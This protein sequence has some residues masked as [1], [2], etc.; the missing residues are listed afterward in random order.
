MFNYPKF[1]EVKGEKYKINT[2][3]KIALKCNE[4]AESDN[5]SKEE[6]S[7]A[8]IYLLFGNEG[9]EASE[10]WKELLKIAIKYLKCG[11]D[12]K[13]DNK[14]ADVSYIQDIRYIETS[15]YYD[16]QID[17]KSTQMHWWEFYE[18]LCGLSEKCILNRIRYIRN[19]D[20]SQIKD[21]KEKQK[22]IEQKELF[23]LKKNNKKREK[24]KRE[25]E[26]DKLFREQISPQRR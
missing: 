24:T 9:L 16:Y 1:A 13:E 21:K 20:I 3:F 22:I 26:L 18:K 11:K 12:I 25:K 19:Y 15:F 4:I 6:R 2:D 5:I 23:S 7:L 10:N 14:E 8:I 17:L